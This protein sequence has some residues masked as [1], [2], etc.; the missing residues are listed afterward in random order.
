MAH[1]YHQNFGHVIFHTGTCAIRRDDLARLHA[2]IAG[3]ALNNGIEKPVVGGTGNHVH[4]LGNFPVSHSVSE[5]V[6]KIKASSSHW[7]KGVHSQY[8]YF[9]WQQGYAYFS[10]SYSQHTKVADYIAHQE[11]HHTHMST[12]EEYT[13]MLEKHALAPASEKN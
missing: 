10:V 3:I 11:E 9:A 8:H 6:S 5:L 2:Y 12:E 7:V 13:R 4:L 1:T